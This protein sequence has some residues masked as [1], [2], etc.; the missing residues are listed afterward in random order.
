MSSTNNDKSLVMMTQM[1]MV[2]EIVQLRKVVANLKKDLESKMT[3]VADL[4]KQSTTLSMDLRRTVSDYNK[5]VKKFEIEEEAHMK[6]SFETSR[7]RDLLVEA[8]KTI[9][10]KKIAITCLQNQVAAHK[11]SAE[12]KDYPFKSVV[13]LSEVIGTQRVTIADLEK[14]LAEAKQ[15]P[16][17]RIVTAGEEDAVTISRLHVANENQAKLIKELQ[18]NYKGSIEKLECD[19]AFLSG[20]NHSLAMELTTVKNEL[21]KC[22]KIYE[23]NNAEIASLKI[24]L[25]KSQDAEK[26]LD[27]R[28]RQVGT[29]NDM[30]I[31]DLNM[32][33]AQLAKCEE[34][35]KQSKRQRGVLQMSLDVERGLTSSYGAKLKAAEEKIFTEGLAKDKVIQALEFSLQAA[36][37]EASARTD[38]YRI[39]KLEEDFESSEKHC[40]ELATE[41]FYLQEDLNKA[42]CQIVNMKSKIATTLNDA[43]YFKAKSRTLKKKVKVLKAAKKA[44]KKESKMLKNVHVHVHHEAGLYEN[45]DAMDW[46]SLYP[47]I[48]AKEASKDLNGSPS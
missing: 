40:S 28:L 32:T 8:Q 37:R 27:L 47:S 6:Q 21:A 30:H 3:Q 23:E 20:Q 9:E 39:S 1:E 19:K 12:D 38:D 2:D 35:L 17:H 34:E 14:Q 18:Q 24:G 43:E 5:L 44:L 26:N 45:V 41:N 10:L 7:V 46:T 31:T 13:E 25:A 33:K 16:Q 36:D 48:L 15:W 42:T 22:H 11:K 4:Q 29:A